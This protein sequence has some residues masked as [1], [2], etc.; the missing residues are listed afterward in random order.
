M[1]I[2]K[3]I[4]LIRMQQ[5]D[6]KC[7][8]QRLS[9]GVKKVKL[10]SQE[11]RRDE[12]TISLNHLIKYSVIVVLH[13]L[14][15]RKHNTI[16]FRSINKL[17]SYANEKDLCE[18]DILVILL[19]QILLVESIGKGKILSKF[20]VT[21]SM[22][23]LKR[24]LVQTEINHTN[25]I[26][27]YWKQSLDYV[28][29]NSWFSIKKNSVQEKKKDWPMLSF[30]LL[31]Y[32]DSK[33]WDRDITNS[34]NIRSQKIRLR[35]TR[36]QSSILRSWIGAAR[37]TY[38]LANASIKT[39][40]KVNAFRLRNRFITRKKNVDNEDIELPEWLF[41][42]PKDIRAW[43][44]REISSCYKTNFKKKEKFNIRYKS[45]K[46]PQQT[47]G[48][49]AKKDI[50]FKYDKK[51]KQNYIKMYPTTSIGLI[52]TE[53]NIPE[54][55]HECKIT[56]IQP[57]HWYLIVPITIDIPNSE[58]ESPKICALDPGCRTFQTGCST[59]GDYF[60][61]GES[62]YE[63][64]KE[65]QKRIDELTSKAKKK[66]KYSSNRGKKNYLKTKNSLD[67][68]RFRLNN[69][70][71]ELHNKTIRY[72]VDNYDVILLPEFASKNMI[73]KKASKFNR[74]ILALK[75][76]KFKMKLAAKCD[77][78]NTR[79]IIVNEA[80]TSKTCCNCGIINSDL[81]SK[82]IFDCRHCQ[83]KIDRDMNG[84]INILQKSH[85][86]LGSYRRSDNLRYLGV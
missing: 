71:D 45:R 14:R 15:E 30:L 41:K 50:H 24:M 29:S 67:L 72:L 44:T 21:P 3:C 16:E 39:D 22:V 64:I 36:K 48:G 57:N 53:K 10:I 27:D 19:S 58:I 79:L 2:W 23:K 69:H 8:I 35:P 43:E 77:I 33:N 34:G 4:L 20:F 31:L 66:E 85:S 68:S 47:I 17:M 65:D 60:K 86:I 52:K 76:Y 73:K 9:I 74:E 26:L 54:I 11:L 61:I 46:S 38:N 59:S 7:Q 75:H 80:Y 28:E 6:L 78:T 82:A 49:I 56:C 5:H 63:K 37:K 13:L 12:E 42:T 18:K 40:S 83:T 81:G 70:I 51:E 55:K 32:S 1:K 62:C 84:A 25:S